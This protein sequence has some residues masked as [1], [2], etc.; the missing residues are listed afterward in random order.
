MFLRDVQAGA[1]GAQTNG[2][3]FADGESQLHRCRRDRRLTYPYTGCACCGLKICHAMNPRTHT[4]ISVENPDD[5]D[6]EY[7][8]E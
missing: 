7:G 5:E 4:M 1:K 8:L 6:D 2:P 3:S